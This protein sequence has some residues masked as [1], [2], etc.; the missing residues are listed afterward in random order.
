[1]TFAIHRFNEDARA[2]LVAHLLALPMTDRRL[3][4]GRSL[5]TSAIAAYVDR[6]DFDRDAVLGIHDDRLALVGV[7]H[8]AI[9]DDVAE[10]AL[11]VLPECRKRGIGSAL[12]KRAMA[13]ARH[14]CVPR[15]FM[16]FWTGN[17]PMF[18]IARR[19]GMDIVASSGGA[20][21]HLKLRR[22]PDPNTARVESRPNY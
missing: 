22:V 11:S 15:L 7:A 12:F 16:Q 1:M 5:T 9:E 21:A 20:E 18:R 17:V 10:L 4:F 6:I 13:H 19:F 14:R 3:R 8:M 2:T